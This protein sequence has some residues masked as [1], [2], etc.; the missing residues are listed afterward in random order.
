[1][2]MLAKEAFQGVCMKITE[3]YEADGWKFLKSKNEMKKK[4][5][6]FTYSV[7]FY[8]SYSNV[9]GVS[10]ELYA[11]FGIMINK[12]KA[13]VW[14]LSTQNCDIPH[15][16]LSWNVATE[17]MWEDAIR[18]FTHWLE[19]E[20]FPVMYECENNPEAL[21]ERIV[22][23]GTYPPRGYH[24]N[25]N[26]ITQFGTREQAEQVAQRLYFEKSEKERENFRVNY[27]S[28][29]NGGEPV[30]FYAKHAMSR[31]SNFRCII[32]NKIPIDFNSNFEGMEKAPFRIEKIDPVYDRATVVYC[33][34][35]GVSAD[36]LTE[37]QRHELDLYAGNHLGFFMAWL[38]KHDY[39]GEKH[40]NSEGV[41]RVKEETMSGTEFLIEYCNKEIW[42]YDVSEEILLF[43]QRYCTYKLFRGYIA[44]VMDVLNDLPMEFIGDWDDYHSYEPVVD[45]AYKKFC[46]EL[47]EEKQKE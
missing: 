39:I 27:E 29:I 37:E 32:E 17:E 40:R 10:V 5:K 23:E 26:F 20:C 3:R 46:E 11:D 38:I 31:Q 41:K 28:M 43:V 34:L 9:S 44:W 4:S 18:E 35:K 24:A 21:A 6:N 30:N 25:L 47:E 12:T 2:F 16:R 8:S 36:S 33:E 45:E 1:M 22:K 14:G 13:G 19:T 7:S 15:G 42:S